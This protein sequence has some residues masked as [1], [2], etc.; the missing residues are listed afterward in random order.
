MSQIR[1]TPQELRDT[2]TFVDQKKQSL[3]QEVEAL[4]TRINDMAANWEGAAQSAFVQTFEKDLYPVLQK[5]MPEVLD[6]IVAQTKGAADAIE[7]TDTEIAESFR[8]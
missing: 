7:A 4:H 3:L 6:G 5:T 1:V 2:A 8:K